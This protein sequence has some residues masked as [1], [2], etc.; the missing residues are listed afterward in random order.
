MCAIHAAHKGLKVLILEKNHKAGM[1]ILVSG[2]GRCNFTNIWSDP[3]EQYLS[4]NPHFCISAM[5]RYSPYD[6]IE[7]VETH[8]IAYHE[9]TLGQ[10][11]CDESS[12]QIQQMLLTECEAA[13]VEIK[14]NCE[15]TSIYKDTT[16][17]DEQQSHSFKVSTHKDS[18]TAPKVVIASGGLSLP[19]IASDLAYKTATQLNLNIIPP[20]AG[21]VP[22]TWNSGDKPVFESLSGI[23]LDA[24]VTCN[25]VSF[26]EALLFTHRGLSGPVILQ[27]SSYWREGDIVFI[28][29][30]PDIDC[31]DWLLT[32]RQ[33][34]PQ[35]K[36][37]NILKSKLP[38]R[39]VELITDNWFADTK[40]GSLSPSQVQ[41]VADRF[42]QWPFKP[43]GT[44][45]YRTA[46]VT[47]G[48]ID[49]D[50]LSSKTLEVKKIPNLYAIG[51]AVDV[52]G[53]LGGYNFQ[54]A[55]ASAYSCALH[56]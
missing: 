44:E 14:L 28:N 24:E 37:T 25:G 20:R 7:M 13:G 32:S 40:I 54:W 10:Q 11:F 39:L 51:E 18:F 6:F 41:E 12:K 43:G 47:L 42:C 3:K 16:A 49:T 17:N 9:K 36:L 38:N 31:K 55:W 5:R 33:E 48:G 22:L 56:L 21:L 29:L 52:T 19:K 30:L 46:E 50:E 26:R 1:K 8:G 45:G 53:W 34:S 15:V 23:S 27:I 35:Q 2:G 4:E